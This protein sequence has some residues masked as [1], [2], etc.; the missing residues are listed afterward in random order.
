M[1]DKESHTT[2]L[3]FLGV[4]LP[5]IGFII[6]YAVDKK[7]KYA[8]YYAKQGLV[9]FILL[10]IVEIAN[11]ILNMIPFVGWVIERVLWVCWIVLWII[12]IVYSLSGKEKDIPVAGEYARK[13]DL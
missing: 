5:L 7:D 10:I 1:K 12:G 9:L 2:L 6:V 4:L 3:A 13:F 8:M 11:L